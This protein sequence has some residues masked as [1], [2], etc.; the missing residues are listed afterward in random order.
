[1]LGI[2]VFQSWLPKNFLQVTWGFIPIVPLQLLCSPCSPKCTP[3]RPYADHI[4]INNI[5]FYFTF[6]QL[7]VT[8]DAKDD[9]YMPHHIVVMGGDSDS[10]KEIS[11][12]FIDA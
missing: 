1:M 4:V 6:R 7:F 11:E 2:T 12:V 10:L 3:C 9:N 5:L 8:V